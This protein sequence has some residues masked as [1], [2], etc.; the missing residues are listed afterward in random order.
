VPILI[1]AVE[2]GSA[3][4]QAAGIVLYAP[5]LPEARFVVGVQR[6]NNEYRGD[7]VTGS[8]YESDES[9]RRRIL[10]YFSTGPIATNTYLANKL[11]EYSLVEKAFVRTTA[12]G[13]VEIWLDSGVVYT[14]GQIKEIFDYIKDYLG[15]G[16]IPLIS[17]VT[18]RAVRL[19]LDIT[20][21]SA[22]LID[23]NGLTSQLRTAIASY[24]DSLTIEQPL[25][26]SQ[27]LNKI[28]P[29]VR[30]AK[31]TT[32]TDDV[33]VTVGELIVLGSVKATYPMN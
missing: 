14:Q 25:I 20:P 15:M 1:E 21:F 24:F 4:N 33:Y 32:P 2:S 19:E 30:E 9:Y 29:F 23:L 8:D 6:Y 7:L 17:Q 11:L 10:N 13:F 28:K 22:S 18:R 31:V 16:M 26:L 5:T 27:V 3:A 12:P